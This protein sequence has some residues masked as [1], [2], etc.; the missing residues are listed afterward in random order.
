MTT[1]TRGTLTLTPILWMDY[2]SH[3]AANTRVHELAN[4]QPALTVRPHQ[5]RRVTVVYLFDDEGASKQCE[6]LHASPGV[7]TVH[8]DDRATASMKYAVIGTVTRDLDAETADIWI[9]SA[10]VLEVTG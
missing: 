5:P 7:I 1:I 4:G 10:E 6:D 3:R 2:E 9:V 8:E